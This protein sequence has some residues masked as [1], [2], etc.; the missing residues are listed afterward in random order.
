MPRLCISRKTGEAFV[1]DTS[2][3]PIT[4]TFIEFDRRGPKV[5]ICI[6]APRQCVIARSELIPD[7]PES[8]KDVMRKEGA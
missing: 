4:V 3:G 8:V 6:E 5:R 1:I 2:D 7:G